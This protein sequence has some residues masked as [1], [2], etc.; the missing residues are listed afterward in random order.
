MNKPKLPQFN[1]GKG[2]TIY[3]SVGILR[4]LVC[5]L[6]HCEV[7][8]ERLLHSIGVDPVILSLPDARI[9]FETYITIEDEAVRVMGD[10]C[11]GLHMGEFF[12]TGNWS[13]LGFM[14]MNCHTLGEAFE[15]A[16][17]YAG[18]VGNLIQ[19][20]VQVRIKTVKLTLSV[21]DYAPKMSRH[22]FESSLASA[23]TLARNLSGREINPLE[24]GF[25]SSLPPCIDEYSRIFR[26][27]VLFDRKDCYMVL[28]SSIATIPVKLPNP[29]LL[30]YFE[31]YA[32]EYLS[33]IENV[34]KVTREVT[35]I[36]LMNL[37]NKAL[38]IGKI[39]RDMA[40]SKRTLQYQLRSEGTEFRTLLQETREKLAKKFLNENYTIE[41]ITYMLGFTDPS[42]FRKSFKKWTGH[43][44]K[45][46]RLTSSSQ[47]IFF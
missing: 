44:P 2:E 16:G 26:C 42:V 5:Y 14:M 9:P 28:D 25:T 27:P 22:C 19:G 20:S 31:N 33:S 13:I 11:F 17:R 39:A 45:E 15:K 30:E 18:I 47:G 32:Q 21:P 4:Q 35:R 34:E 1:Y 12:E 24:V 37:D 46:F 41:D 23:V 10:P 7:N 8:V 36:I 29:A 38:T 43:T 6:K 40:V 3:V